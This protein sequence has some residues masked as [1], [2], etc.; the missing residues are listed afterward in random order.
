LVASWF[1]A[2]QQAD[3]EALI[4]WHCD[5]RAI[6]H[7][8]ASQP[9]TPEVV[10]RC[11]EC[12]LRDSDSDESDNSYCMSITPK[13]HPRVI[14][15]DTGPRCWI[16]MDEIR[17]AL[18]SPMIWAEKVSSGRAEFRLLELFYLFGA[19]VA[20]LDA[21]GEPELTKNIVLKLNG[22]D[23]Y[24]PPVVSVA[25]LKRMTLANIGAGI[26]WDGTRGRW[27]NIKAA[28][29][30]FGSGSASGIQHDIG[31]T[32]DGEIYPLIKCNRFDSISAAVNDFRTPKDGMAEHVTI[33]DQTA[34]RT[35]PRARLPRTYIGSGAEMSVVHTHLTNLRKIKNP[36]TGDEDWAEGIENHLGL[37]KVYARLAAQVVLNAPVLHAGSPH[38]LGNSRRGDALAMRRERSMAG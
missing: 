14:G 11:I 23:T 26:T 31:R 5:R 15:M 1:A 33:N 25:E 22:L 8:G 21:G 29:V 37:A 18:C 4:A 28:A 7:A 32:V 3:G 38:R 19:D 36:K 12:G 2:L 30:L 24:S 16:W 34:L 13:A 10:Q 9:I 6:P 17:S 35:M 27:V 20:F